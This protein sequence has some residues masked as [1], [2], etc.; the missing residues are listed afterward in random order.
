MPGSP[1]S[2]AARELQTAGVDVEI[3]EA[4]DRI[5]G[6]AWTEERM[7]RPLDWVHWM[8]RF[9]W[10]EIARYGQEIYPSPKYDSAYWITDGALVACAKERMNELLERPQEKIFEGSK[11]FFPYPHDRLYVLSDRYQG[12]DEVVDRFKAADQGEVLDTLRNGDFSQE[13]ID[14]CDAYWSAAYQGNL[15]TASPLMA[16][17]WASLSDHRLF[18][19]DEQTLEFKLTNG[20]RGLYESIAADLRCPIHLSSPVTTVE[21]EG[22]ARI[23]LADGTTGDGDAVIVTT[24]CR[25]DQHN[26]LPSE[27]APTHAVHRRR[28]DE[29]Q[30]LQDLDQDRRTPFLPGIGTDGQSARRVEDHSQSGDCRRQGPPPERQI[31]LRPLRSTAEVGPRRRHPSVLGAERSR[32]FLSLVL[33]PCRQ[34]VDGV[35]PVCRG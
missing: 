4:R 1:D 32:S 12:P 3:F 24:P 22:G 23:T 31:P 15:E 29:Q 5:G 28:E 6:R 10:A 27:S 34:T 17:H 35:S 14:L 20:M 30:R 18:L 21:H 26:R 7:G 9:V 8:Q 11:D 13:E 33:Q 19:L 2:F 16:K 25:C